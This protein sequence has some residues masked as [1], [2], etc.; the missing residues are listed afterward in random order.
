MTT[1]HHTFALIANGGIHNYPIIKPL[2]KAHECII[3]VDG[4][5]QHC[6]KMKITPDMIVG[7]MDSAPSELLQHYAEVP[8]RLFP[9]HKDETDMEL[10]V[11][12]VFTPQVEKI[13]LFGALE[14]RTDHALANMHLIRRYPQKVYIE[15]ETE[16]I[17]AFDGEVEIPCIPGQTIA[18][19]HL[20]D[21][22]AGVTSQGLKWELCDA[23]FS[24][25]FMSISNICVENPVRLNLKKGDL[26]CVLQ[27]QT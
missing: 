22:V 16:F 13:T 6:H 8:V 24:K 10:A 15:T 26:L 3:A 27:K 20:G 9:K 4:G 14:K 17:F 7:D 18:F 1:F 2:I 21:P 23:T 5:I 25:Y 19:I 11:Q 12:S